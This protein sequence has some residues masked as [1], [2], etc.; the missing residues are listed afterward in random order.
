MGS[1]G[2]LTA[3]ASAKRGVRGVLIDGAYESTDNV[4][5]IELIVTVGTAFE[6]ADM[7]EGSRQS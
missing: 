6:L 7:L 1:R 4:L 5:G 3:V 2:E